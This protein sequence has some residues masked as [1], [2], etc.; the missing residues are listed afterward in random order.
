MTTQR[1]VLLLA[2]TVP[3]WAFA[4]GDGTHAWDLYPA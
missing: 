2:K 4:R 1:N 3:R